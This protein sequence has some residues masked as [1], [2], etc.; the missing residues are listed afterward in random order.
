MAKLANAYDNRSQIYIRSSSSD[1][2]DNE[3]DCNLEEL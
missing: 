3:Q 2:E 1:A